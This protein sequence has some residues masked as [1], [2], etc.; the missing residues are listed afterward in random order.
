[1]LITCSLL[2][3]CGRL[4]LVFYFVLNTALSKYVDYLCQLCL[5]LSLRSDIKRHPI[6]S[7]VFGIG[8]NK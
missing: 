7:A 3:M 1:M 2:R 8:A 4:D 6:F 5:T